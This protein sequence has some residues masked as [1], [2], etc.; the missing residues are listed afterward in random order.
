MYVFRKFI[1]F[2]NLC[3][4]RSIIKRQKARP[5]NMKKATPPIGY[6]GSLKDQATFGGKGAYPS[7]G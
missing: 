4:S 1:F 7:E 3:Y 6:N 2:F 5:D